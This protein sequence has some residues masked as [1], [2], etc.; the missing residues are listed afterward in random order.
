M[1]LHMVVIEQNFKSLSLSEKYSRV[2]KNG[3]FIAER[4]FGSFYVQLF[5]LGNFYAEVWRKKGINQIS[6]IEV[7]TKRNVA[8]NYLQGIDIMGSLGLR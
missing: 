7:P 3:R 2:K 1:Y 4:S 5:T 6:W 8:D